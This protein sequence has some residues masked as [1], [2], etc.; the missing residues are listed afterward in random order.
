[1]KRSSGSA[2]IGLEP[3]PPLS[4]G[5]PGTIGPNSDIGFGCTLLSCVTLPWESLVC[6]AR[7]GL[8]HFVAQVTD[9]TLEAIARSDLKLDTLQ[10][11]WWLLPCRRIGL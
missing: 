6:M 2:G 11:S 10:L 4:F 5:V 7:T 3:Q 1:M 9:R 8:E